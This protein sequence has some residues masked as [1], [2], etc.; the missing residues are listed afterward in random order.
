MLR[1]RAAS[2]RPA[3]RGQPVAESDDKLPPADSLTVSDVDTG[4]L[5]PPKLPPIPKT[6]DG[7]GNRWALTSTE[8]TVEFVPSELA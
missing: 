4:S 3:H 6:P 1:I 8:S 2:S 7:T 5:S